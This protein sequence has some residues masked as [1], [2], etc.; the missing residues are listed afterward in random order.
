MRASCL[1]GQIS[2]REEAG[3]RTSSGIDSVEKLVLFTFRTY[4][5]CHRCWGPGQ[6]VPSMNWKYPVRVRVGAQADALSRPVADTCLGVTMVVI[7]P[8][9]EF[10]PSS[11]W[12]L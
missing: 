10:R 12:N 6:G 5:T 11:M 3:S 7:H 8:S 1:L 4:G 9:L 2:K